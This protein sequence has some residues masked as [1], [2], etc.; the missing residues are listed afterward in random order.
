MSEHASHCLPQ[1]AS[2]V[3]RDTISQYDHK[4]KHHYLVT[5]KAGSL[6]TSGPT[7]TWPCSMKVTAV[8]RSGAILLRTMRQGRRRRQKEEAVTLLH[9]LRF[10]LVG[11]SPIEYLWLLHQSGTGLHSVGVLGVQLLD[12]Q[13]QLSNLS[14]HL[15]VAVEWQTLVQAG[16]G[17]YY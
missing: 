3:C 6:T 16:V 10:H 11:M 17:G 1:Q 12:L 14:G 9:S 15:V 4:G 13:G 7:L 5:R 8:R 2:P